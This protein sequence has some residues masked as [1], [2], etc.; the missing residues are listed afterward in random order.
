M[1]KT[2]IQQILLQ[3]KNKNKAWL[4]QKKKKQKLTFNKLNLIRN[5]T[6]IY[7]N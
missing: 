6:I 7:N 2:I 1:C 5:N 3:I 4:W